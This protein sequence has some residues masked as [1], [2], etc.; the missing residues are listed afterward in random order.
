VTPLCGSSVWPNQC[1][2]VRVVGR[3]SAPPSVV[4][5]ALRVASSTTCGSADV[6]ALVDDDDVLPDVDVVAGGAGSCLGGFP[7][8]DAPVTTTATSDTTR[9]NVSASFRKTISSP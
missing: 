7:C 1:G 5:Y 3:T 9:A 8:A 2:I 4:V 6:D